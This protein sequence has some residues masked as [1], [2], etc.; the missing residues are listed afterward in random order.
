MKFRVRTLL[1]AIFLAATSSALAEEG[2]EFVWSGFYAGAQ[3]GYA[4]GDGN[5]GQVDRPASSPCCWNFDNGDAVVGLYAGYNQAINPWLLL[6]IET[7]LNTGVNFGTAPLHADGF[8]YPLGAYDGSVDL[9][10][11]GT[12]KGRLGASLGRLGRFMPYV[13]IGVAYGRFD[14]DSSLDFLPA[15]HARDYLTGWAGAAGAEYA[16][17]KNVILR[18]QYQF[19]DFE[20]DSFQP[21]NAAGYPF[22]VPLN[23]SFEIHQ[24]TIGASYKF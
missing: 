18:G 2:S 11:F 4:S 5:I 22:D 15:S 10:W 1:A 6:G 23:S 16:V 13:A 8:D 19:I 21:Y 14:F 17:S 7:E 12:T 24:F 20:N 9:E 3:V